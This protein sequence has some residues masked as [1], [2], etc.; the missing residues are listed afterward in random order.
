VEVSL[1]SQDIRN[2]LLLQTISEGGTYRSL[3]QNH[4]DMI[5]IMDTS[6]RYVEVNPSVE[7]ITGFPSEEFL[8]LSA[9][10]M[11]GRQESGIRSNAFRQA[12]AGEPSEFEVDFTRKDGEI[13]RLFVMYVPIVAEGMVVGVY[14]IGKDITARKRAEEAL[15]RNEE[16]LAAAQRIAGLGSYEWDIATGK[17]SFSDEMR[18]IFRTSDTTAPS[19]DYFYSLLSENDRRRVGEA[20]RRALDEGPF[21]IGYTIRFPDGV[22]REIFAQGSV[23]RDAEGRPERMIGTAFDTTERSE[24]EGRLRESE[25]KYRLIS[26]NSQDLI[27]R[28]T[29]DADANYL[30][31]SP[32][33]TS[34]LGYRP[35]EMTGKSAYAFIHPED[36]GSVREY[37]GRLLS[38]NGD[39]TVA[40]RICRKDGTYI[41]FESTGRYTFDEDSGSIQE[42]V[43]ISRDIS[44]RKEAERRL[45]ESEQR[46]RSLFEY[47]PA[48]VY[49]L[50]L[51]GRYTSVNAHMEKLTGFR[52]QE[53]LSMSYK[54]LVHPRD[55]E[56][57]A[58]RFELAKTGVPQNYETRVIHKDGYPVIC[59][60]TNVPIVV[61]GQIV[62]VYGIANDITERKQYIEQI[63]KLSNQQAMLL[64]SVSEGIYGLDRQAR[65]VFINPAGLRM[66]GYRQEEVLG[67][68]SHALFHHTRPD[69]TPYPPEECPIRRTL[70]DGQPQSVS[71]EVFWRKDGSSFLVEYRVNPIYDNGEIQGAVVVFNDVTDEREIVRAKESAE[72][73]DRAKSEFLAMMSHEIRTPMNGIIGMTD[74]LLDTE[75]DGEQREY[76]EIIN[77]SS[78]SLLR[79]IND[80][81]DFSKIEAGK[82]ELEDEPFDIRAELGGVVEL[83]ESRAE[84]KGLELALDVDPGLPRYVQGDSSRFR[85]VMLN[86]VGNA[87][88]FTEKGKIRVSAS[89]PDEGGERR[90]MVFAV[91][92]TG[93][94]IPADKLPELFQSFSQLHPAINRKYGGTGLGLAISRKL[95]ELM[96]GVIEV[97][98]AE[99]MGS[100]FRFVLPVKT[101]EAGTAAGP[102]EAAAPEPDV[103]ALD[104]LRILLAEDHPV[105]QQLLLRILEKLGLAAD[106]VQNGV[107]AVEAVT[108]K[109]YDIVFMDVQMPMLDGLEA[110]R[111]IRQVLPPDRMPVIAALTAFARN[112]DR[113]RCL[114]AGMDDYLSKPISQ[115]DVRRVLL[116]WALFRK[117]G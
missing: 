8:R 40:Y 24:M 100:T 112:E 18:R 91:R 57:V 41:W 51:E 58:E 27:S 105:N 88:K 56:A 102:D 75:L 19:M 85:Q 14:G 12:A 103:Q 53:L 11:L 99:G 62:G 59:G 78:E 22:Q 111:L 16:M 42:I 90:R 101:P 36:A 66:L 115:E 80:I 83:F 48:A 71:E 84:E 52:K 61:D 64:N 60:V 4:P 2:K 34:L 72:R 89:C 47:N 25:K 106:V 35:E 49:S 79:I 81:L 29:A 65:T 97:E 74:L 104:G 67:R 93:I 113:E 31:V 39:Y 107:E 82:M 117:P 69:G 9:E 3:F 63:E 55:M 70:R 33:C 86:L 26:D 17:W 20:V 54:P 110:T 46:Y 109:R 108:E 13:I 30:Y 32:S 23:L 10:Q 114:A 98:S 28:H 92:D 50:D 7:R 96:G 43:A 68:Q 45:E 5:Y 77:A 1:T 21:E 37:L 38:A 15:R 87:M 95:A 94:G 76:A 44:D 73:A 116:K 6:G